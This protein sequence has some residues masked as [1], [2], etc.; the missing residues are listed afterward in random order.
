M[1]RVYGS[2]TFLD[3]F[4]CGTDFREIEQNILTKVKEYLYKESINGHISK[5]VVSLNE[6]SFNYDQLLTI[7]KTQIK[8]FTNKEIELRKIENE[9]KRIDLINNLL[10]QNFTYE[11]ISTL[12]NCSNEQKTIIQHEIQQS[13]NEEIK[14]ECTIIKKGRKIQVISPDNLNIIVK[15]YDSM[16]FALRDVEHMIN[17]VYKK[18]SKITQS[19]KILDGYL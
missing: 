10:K 11:Q 16:I 18:S 8:N 1:K 15:I 17:T 2:C 14:V 7:V 5:E 13:K 3:I 19:I 12:V 6:L 9:T 4:E